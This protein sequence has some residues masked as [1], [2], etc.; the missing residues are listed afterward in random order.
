MQSLSFHLPVFDGPMDLLLHLID[1]HKLDIYDIPIVE[2]KPLARSLYKM[3]EVD[4]VIPVELYTA[5]AE[6]L[7]Y[8]YNKNKDGVR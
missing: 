6:V 7:S 1:K 4:R 2:N 5:V 8:V 3:V